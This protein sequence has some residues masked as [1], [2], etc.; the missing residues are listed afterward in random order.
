MDQFRDTRGLII[1]VRD[2]SGGTRNILRTLYPYFCKSSD[3]PIVANAAKY[4]LYREFGPGYLNSRHMYPHGWKGW[5]T[6]ER[7]AIST[8]MQ[9]FKPEWTVPEYEFSEY[10]FWVLSKRTNPEAYYYSKPVVFLIDQKGFSA[11][12]VIISGLKGRKNITLIGTATG[13]GSGAAQSSL[14]KN[15]QLR[16]RLSS[17]ASFQKDGKLFDGNGVQPDIFIEPLPEY[18]LKNGKDNV[19]EKAIR[20][21]LDR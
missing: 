3:S 4:R 7:E 9:T 14:L 1:D 19:L 2:N 15:S 13:G 16:L 21:I 20:F 6:S 12:G 5:D 10:H 18:F 8:F 17:M 11:T